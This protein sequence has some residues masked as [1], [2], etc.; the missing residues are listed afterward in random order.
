MDLNKLTTLA[1]KGIQEIIA[2]QKRILKGI[3][4]A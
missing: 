4:I 2:A 3:K 1:E